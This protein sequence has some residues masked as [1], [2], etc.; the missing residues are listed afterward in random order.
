MSQHQKQLVSTVFMAIAAN[1][2]ASIQTT[3]QLIPDD[4]LGAESTVVESQNAQ[5][6]L[7]KGGAI[8]NINLFHSFQEFNIASGQEV[9]FANPDGILNILT[10]VTGNN[11]SNI[12]GNLGVNGNANLFLINPNGIL[13][14]EGATVDLNGSFLAST[15]ESI[16]FVNGETFSAINPEQ[17]PLLSVNIPLGVQLGSDAASVRAQQANIQAKNVSL[18]GGD[19]SLEQST[20]A[21]PD[22]K[23]DLYS[24]AEAGTVNFNS[25]LLDLARGNITIRD[26]SSI[27]VL[28]TGASSIA[29]YADNI[30][31]E[32]QSKLQAGIAEGWGTLNTVA[33]EIKLNATGDIALNDSSTIFQRLKPT[34]QG[35][36]GDIVATAD[37][38][39]LRDRSKIQT[40]TESS[41]DAGNITI[42]ARQQVNLESPPPDD[43]VE[44]PRDLAFKTLILSQVK[45]TATGNGGN[46]YL[47]TPETRINLNAEIGTGVL[48]EGNGGDL[49]LTTDILSITNGA[50][51]SATTNSL[52]DGGNVDIKAD[53][54]ELISNNGRPTRIDSV[55]RS[56]ATGDGGN[57]DIETRE[58]IIEGGIVTADTMSDGNGGTIFVRASDRIELSKSEIN[59]FSGIFTATRREATGNGGD[60]TLTT[61]YLL[62]QPGIKIDASTDTVGN[63]GNIEIEATELIELQGNDRDLF[64]AIYTQT[65]RMSSGNGGN[66]DLETPIL[67][68]SGGSQV[69]AATLGSG[70]GGSVS[71]ASDSIELSGNIPFQTDVFRPVIPVVDS[72][73]NKI[74]S[75]IYASSP[76]LGNADA[77]N[78]ATENLSLNDGAQISVSSLQQGAAG[79]L[80]IAADTISLNNSILSAET[81]EGENANIA[82]DTSN[83]QLRDRSLITTNATQAAT[84]GNIEI[85]TDILLAL[86]NSD[87]TANASDNFGGRVSIE[88]RGIFGTQVREFLTP[89]SDITA[90]SRL[91][92]EFSGIVELDLSDAD[93]STR[94]IKLPN[95]LLDASEQI[96]S[97]CRLNRD[98]TFVVTGSGL[99]PNPQSLLR[100]QNILQDW[101]IL[102]GDREWTVETEELTIDKT[103]E[104]VEAEKL[105][106]NQHGVLELVAN[107]SNK[108]DFWKLKTARCDV[109]SI[110]SL[111]S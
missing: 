73:A 24:L 49:Y 92:A 99:A 74:R 39:V 5:Q 103:T 64:S 59:R 41:G 25:D 47:N 21:V 87:I 22:G 46:I 16:N 72:S 15:A 11:V 7:I 53:L 82:I 79:N 95:N 100:S 52:G 31:F 66:V 93:P 96:T 32:A 51:V 62:L 35:S 18:I 111:K 84:G 27:D 81:V 109:R 28:G 37:N 9:N 29:I 90:T 106:V 57:I 69:S 20:I 55:T 2:I 34:S 101:R 107:S 54:I 71:I 42:D 77:L 13:L 56:G 43:T 63:G 80:S 91:G 75:G 67:R 110:Q 1:T 98:N 105:I 4:T 44:N 102:T 23:V 58:L 61:P 48:G 76:G 33:G 83:L 85:D 14:G 26:R 40:E 45:E 88:A 94:I 86:D 30:V 50:N 70:A 36:G 12:F 65:N 19:I 78:I 104:V 38:L 6:F 8:N 97:S 10:R 68:L 3:A 17:S 108:I 89:Q 60:I